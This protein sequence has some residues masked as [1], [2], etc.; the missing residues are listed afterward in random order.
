MKFSHIAEQAA[1]EFKT[2]RRSW[3]KFA[4]ASI[5]TLELIERYQN[6]PVAE[7]EALQEYLRHRKRKLLAELKIAEKK[8]EYWERAAL[9]IAATFFS[10]MVWLATVAGF[11]TGAPRV[12]IPAIAFVASVALWAG[13]RYVCWM[14]LEAS[15]RD[16]TEL[17]KVE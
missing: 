8:A 3:K 17:G 5:N 12:V 10:V 6:L 11:T 1:A 15:I 4:S 7:R 14:W 16:Q 9:P 13:I 2:R